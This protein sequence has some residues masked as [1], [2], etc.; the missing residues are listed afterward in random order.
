MPKTGSQNTLGAPQS[1]GKW[2][3]VI[4]LS[5]IA[6][7]LLIEVG[8]PARGARAAAG[9]GGKAEIFAVAGQITR[10]TYGMYLVDLEGRTICVYQYVPT[11]RKLH[12]RAARNITFDMQL[13]AYNTELPP[14]EIKK[15]VEQHRR[16]KDKPS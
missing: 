2:V 4:L 8:L 9:S 15:L 14:Q 5:V 13:D 3:I 11:T 16:L 12:L 7:C 6:T 1:A 10:D